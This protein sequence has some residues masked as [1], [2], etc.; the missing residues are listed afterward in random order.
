MDF[1]DFYWR[2]TAKAITELAAAAKRGGGQDWLVGVFYGYLPQ[3]GGKMQESQH[4]GI[5]TV[6]E[7][8]DIDFLCSPAMYS[9]RGPGGASNFMSFTESIKRRGKLWWHEADNRTHRS[10]GDPFGKVA[11]AQNL[12]E[13]VNVLERE[14]A[15]CLTEAAGLWWFDMGG[16][17]YDE[18][19]LMERVAAT[20][21]L[22]EEDPERLWKP[23]VEIGLFIDAK[24]SYRMPP[25][26][27]YLHGMTQLVAAMPRL[28]APYRTYLLSD[29]PEAPAYRALLLPNAFD[30][31]DHERAAIEQ[32]VD[33][34]ATVVCWGPAGAGRFEA[35]R[36]TPAPD[37]AEALSR[38]AEEGPGRVLA[39][40]TPS[41]GDIATLREALEAANVRIYTSTNDAFYIGEGYVALHAASAGVKKLEFGEPLEVTEVLAA[42]G[43]SVTA[44]EVEA[45]FERYET[46]VWRL[47]EPR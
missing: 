11:P 42:P 9:D 1:Y 36:V 39:R 34:G 7:S 24:S 29:L 16:G 14:F 43:A 45:R 30:L 20:R 21:A 40:K 12:F 32:R 27:P 46:R 18:P 4:L 47:Q 35:G 15:H 10:I 3:Y 33:Q 2:G 41:A 28:G 5:E 26:S 13:S 22:A 17:W 25:E 31:T 6:L 23:D 8:P 38:R 44:D 37:W 19:E